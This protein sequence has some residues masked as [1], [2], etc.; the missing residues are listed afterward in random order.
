MSAE[1]ELFGRCIDMNREEVVYALMALDT[2]LNQVHRLCIE[3]GPFFKALFGEMSS[4]A[5]RQGLKQKLPRQPENQS[6]FARGYWKPAISCRQ[7]EAIQHTVDAFSAQW[8]VFYEQHQRERFRPE[9]TGV[10]TAS[11]LSLLDDEIG[12]LTSNIKKICQYLTSAADT[13]A[14]QQKTDASLSNLLAQ[15]T[16]MGD[17]ST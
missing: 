5:Q 3:Q 6:H 1:G 8:Q 14:T 7:I 4:D 10:Y 11:P 15:L 2:E 9:A 12:T 17:C 16:Q 13:P